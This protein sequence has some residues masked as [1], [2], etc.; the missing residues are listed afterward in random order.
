M[1]GSDGPARG[2]ADGDWRAQINWPQVRRLV[3]LHILY[4]AFGAVQVALYWAGMLA[5]PARTVLGI[6][7]YLA[8]AVL[9]VL[10][11]RLIVRPLHGRGSAYMVDPR[12]FL[13]LAAFM[14]SLV[15]YIGL[16]GL[17]DMGTIMLFV[18]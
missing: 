5:G 2:S 3:V 8:W 1:S 18:K 6:A 7:D 9:L 12:G 10:L 11:G 17:I 13:I 16:L 15:A 4:W 14:A